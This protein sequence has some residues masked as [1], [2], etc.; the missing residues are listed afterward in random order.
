MMNCLIFSLEKI[1]LYLQKKTNDFQ[2]LTLDDCFEQIEE[3]KLLMDR[4]KYIA[5]F[6]EK[7]QMLFH[8]INY[9]IVQKF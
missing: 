6:V 7:N 9:K 4:I 2:Y 3:K 5:I 8:I 1:R